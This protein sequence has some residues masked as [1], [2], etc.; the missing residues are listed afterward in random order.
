M[1]KNLLA[2]LKTPSIHTE[3][4]QE[5]IL[6]L[7]NT[8]RSDG[9]SPNEIVFGRNLRSLLPIHH[10]AF[11]AKWKRQ[12]DEA[13][14]KRALIRDKANEHYNRTA[15]D[16]KP[17]RIGEK[18]RVQNHETARWDRIGFIVGV[19]MNRDYRVKLPS[20]RTLWRNRRHLRRV[21]DTIED[22]RSEEDADAD[23]NDADNTIEREESSP[24]MPKENESKSE[25]QL[26]RKGTRRRKK[27]VRF[28]NNI[29]H[30]LI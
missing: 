22:E 13:D 18:V 23:I 16:L 12:A 8:P 4:F 28:G 6:E 17:F 24:P 19:G 9:R 7:R 27:T 5:A 29:V 1:L 21:N 15:R 3:E 10:T 11:D 14:A 30:C 26:L 20:G 2:K 25:T